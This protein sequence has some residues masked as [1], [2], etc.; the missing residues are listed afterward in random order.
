MWWS[1]FDGVDHRFARILHGFFPSASQVVT[2][3]LI[4]FLHLGCTP[5]QPEPTYAFYHWQTELEINDSLLTTHAADRLYIKAFDVSWENGRAQPSAIL[6]ADNRDSTTET[7]PSPLERA[8]VRVEAVPVIFITNEVFTHPTGGLAQDI[9]RL[10]AQSFPFPYTELQIDC[11]WTAGTRVQYFSFLQSLREASGK[12]I[13]ATVRLHQYRDR[14]AQGIPPVDRGVLMA[15]NTGDLGSWETENSIVDTAIIEVYVAGQPPYPL[16]LDL[17][18]AV[19]DWAAVYRR[20]ELAYLINEPDLEE[21]A[22]TT[23]FTA[24]GPLRYRVDSSTYYDGLYL[25][26]GDLLRREIAGREEAFRLAEDLWPRVAGADSRY[27]IFYRMGSRG[28]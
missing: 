2:T 1:L 23:R 28:W 22:D 16:P 7:T 19:Y 18:V 6:L 13:S 15:Y 21:L 3:T 20:G 10:L 9:L 14:A 26:R 24:T 8:G 5:D 4:L 17:A 25:Y 11:D 27:V 12:Q